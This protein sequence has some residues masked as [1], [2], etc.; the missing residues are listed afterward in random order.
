MEIYYSE[1]VWSLDHEQLTTWLA[2]PGSGPLRSL[3]PVCPRSPEPY[4]SSLSVSIAARVWYRLCCVRTK[5]TFSPIKT[6]SFCKDN[7]LGGFEFELDKKAK[8]GSS[9]SGSREGRITMPGTSGALKQKTSWHTSRPKHRIR[10][11]SAQASV[12]A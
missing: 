3:S 10:S 6:A 2:I 4:W 9:L 11:C 8:A 5:P 12:S 7:D 1:V